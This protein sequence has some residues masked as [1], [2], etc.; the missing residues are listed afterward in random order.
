[1]LS[2]SVSVGRNEQVLSD[3]S[4]KTLPTL[5]FNAIKLSQGE[6]TGS[7]LQAQNTRFFVGA[8]LCEDL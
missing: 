6:H 7:P 2:E 1:M 8:Y 4:R 5:R 3:L